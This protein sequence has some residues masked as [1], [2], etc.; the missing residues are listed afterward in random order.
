[1][2]RQ[3][4]QWSSVAPYAGH[5][6][7]GPCD[8]SFGPGPRSGRQAQP[9]PITGRGLAANARNACRDPIIAALAASRS[10]SYPGANAGRGFAKGTEASPRVLNCTN[11]G[12]ASDVT[13]EASASRSTETMTIHRRRAG[14]PLCLWRPSALLST[15]AFMLRINQG[16]LV[17][18]DRRDDDRRKARP[19]K[20]GQ[21]AFARIPVR[22]VQTP[23]M[24]IVDHQPVDSDPENFPGCAI[25]Q[26]MRTCVPIGASA[27]SS[28]IPSL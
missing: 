5:A 17:G 25:C 28:S 4:W 15:I 11:V 10:F 23:L 20:T 22:G 13:P 19:P 26:M 27:K 3:S 8:L 24:A 9:S 2:C 16:I 6:Q 1:M 18:V 7:I 21:D 12:I 14:W